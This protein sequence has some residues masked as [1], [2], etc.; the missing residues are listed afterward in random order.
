MGSVFLFMSLANIADIAPFVSGI[1]GLVLFLV[2]V[3]VSIRFIN[4]YRKLALT[5]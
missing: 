5:K 1:I 4:G 3:P 2:E